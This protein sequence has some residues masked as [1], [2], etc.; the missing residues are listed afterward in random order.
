MNDEDI[1]N[2]I[3]DLNLIY[4]KKMNNSK[5]RNNLKLI[6]NSIKT[7]NFSFAIK[8]LLKKRNENAIEKPKKI[9]PILINS[10]NNNRVA[11][12]TCITGNYD[13]VC[14]PYII[15]SN[16]DY[17][18]FTNNKKINS[19]VWKKKDIPYEMQNIGGDILI[20]RYIKM[21]PYELFNENDYDYAVYIDGNIS[22]ISNISTFCDNTSNKTGLAFHKHY[23]KTCTYD[24]MKTCEII[25]K[26]NCKKIKMQEKKYKKEGFPKNY[27]L[28]EC[29]VI[30]SNLHN[31]IGKEILNNWWS[32]FEKSSSLRDQICLP[33]SLW[34]KGYKSSDI[35]IIENN[36]FLNKKIR[37]NK[38]I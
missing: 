19:K 22:I 9:N 7:F 25:G 14:E 10:K 23:N 8:R 1:L 17:Y 2:V 27:G 12:Y 37:I 29:N 16:C 34:K 24:E 38:H 33:Y 20:N 21:H 5:K 11:I 13:N 18:I 35:G 3:E 36:V 26:G 30:V 4:L 32:E 28:F 6:I 31:S 15:E